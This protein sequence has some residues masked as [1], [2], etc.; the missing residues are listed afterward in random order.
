MT[1]DRA[2]DARKTDPG[3]HR[4]VCQNP[5]CPNGYH[6]RTANPRA[7]YCCDAC[8]RTAQNAREYA[9][10]AGKKQANAYTRKKTPEELALSAAGLWKRP[11]GNPNCPNG[12]EFIT[13]HRR[14][15]YCDEVCKKAAQNARNYARRKARQK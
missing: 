6:F 13:A 3:G 7:L 12:G 15:R 8:Q 14:A 2:W 10:R 5:N 11:C 4:R 9:R 1:D